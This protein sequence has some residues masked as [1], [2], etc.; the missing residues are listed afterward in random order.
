ME[1]VSYDCGAT[2]WYG[3]NNALPP[4]VAPATEKG[5]WRRRIIQPERR[6][7]LGVLIDAIVQL[8]RLAA[9]PPGPRRAQFREAERWVRSND[10]RWPFS[11][12]NV[13]EALELAYEPL[14]R[15]LLKRAAEPSSGQQ[16]AAVGKTLAKSLRRAGCAPATPD[17]TS[18]RAD[19]PAAPRARESGGE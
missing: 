1:L 3:A 12:V 15:A 14:R 2:D 17:T 4:D 9:T 10:R 19:A 18:V 11:F 13:C 6:L 5:D 16:D 7:L 8:E